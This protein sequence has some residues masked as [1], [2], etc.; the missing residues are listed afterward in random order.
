MERIRRW[1]A[2]V[3]SPTE[4]TLF[5]RKLPEGCTTAKLMNWADMC[6]LEGTYDFVHLPRRRHGFINFSGTDPAL[7]FQEALRNSPGVSVSHSTTQGLELL[8][9]RFLHGRQRHAQPAH[10][11]PFVRQLWRWGGFYPTDA[12]LTSLLA[13]SSRQ[14][15]LPMWLGA[16]PAAAWHRPA[17]HDACA[18]ELL[19]APPVPRQAHDAPGGGVLRGAPRFSPC[20]RQAASAGRAPP[21]G[22]AVAGALTEVPAGRGEGAGSGAAGRAPGPAARRAA[23]AAEHASLGRAR[24][25]LWPGEAAGAWCGG[26]GAAAWGGQVPRGAWAAAAPL[27][28]LPSG[29]TLVQRL[30]L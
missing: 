5:L 20:A 25:A 12:V 17:A 11:L 1:A 13:P 19:A 22:P 28:R 23:A 6:G 29:F 21:P 24:C 14:V 16:A 15:P 18:H 8:M 7:R 30:N 27:G 4:V 2:D 26:E 3:S 9:A 10:A